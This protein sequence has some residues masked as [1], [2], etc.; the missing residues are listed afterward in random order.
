ME[1]DSTIAIE[2]I[3]RHDGPPI[4]EDLLR[5]AVICT[6]TA[7][8]AVAAEISLALVNDAEIHR[9]NRDFLG[10]DYPT[11]VISFPLPTDDSLAACAS[12]G[13]PSNA[14]ASRCGAST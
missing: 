9:I 13:E 11:D 6:L 3:Q 8:G 1:Q 2:T 10:H 14:T 4:A 5:R 12:A 7:E